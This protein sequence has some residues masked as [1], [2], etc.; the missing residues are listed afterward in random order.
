MIP[1]N[2]VILGNISPPLD[3]IF[4]ASPND[5]VFANALTKSDP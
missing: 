3:A 1:R 4:N 5:P 2:L